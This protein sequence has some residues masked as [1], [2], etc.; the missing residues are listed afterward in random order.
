MADSKIAKPYVSHENVTSK[1]TLS[2]TKANLSQYSA[3]K[4]GSLIS[5]AFVITLTTDIAAKEWISFIPTFSDN[6]LKP[7]Q[8]SQIGG[9]NQAN[10]NIFISDLNNIFETRLISA[11]TSGTAF[12]LNFMYI[13]SD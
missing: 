9:S 2:C 12:W 1:I 11:Y 8:R 7:I 13:C 4:T 10:D 6:R 3:I 5:L